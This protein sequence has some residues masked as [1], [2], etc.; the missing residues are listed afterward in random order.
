MRPYMNTEGKGKWSNFWGDKVKAKFKRLF[1][2]SARQ[3]G[4]K[5][6]KDSRD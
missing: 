6:T 5:Q 4:K 3:E 2:K 1:G